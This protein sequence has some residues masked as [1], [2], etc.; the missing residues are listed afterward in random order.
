MDDT[1]IW[2][3]GGI[4]YLRGITYWPLLPPEEAEQF[5]E[6][7]G[8]N[9]LEVNYKCGKNNDNPIFINWSDTIPSV[10]LG[11]SDIFFPSKNIS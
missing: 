8:E 6:K 3:V 4:V 10:Q 9:A 5:E 7:M 11:I 1:K 2:W